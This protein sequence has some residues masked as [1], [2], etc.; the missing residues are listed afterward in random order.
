MQRILSLPH[1]NHLKWKSPKLH[2]KGGSTSRSQQ[3]RDAAQT[4][5][6]KQ[7]KLVLPGGHLCWRAQVAGTARCHLQAVT[8]ADVVS[9]S[10][11]EDPKEL[12]VQPAQHQPVPLGAGFPSQPRV[13]QGDVRS[14][15]FCCLPLKQRSPLILN[16]LKF[17]IRL[18]QLPRN[19]FYKQH[20]AINTLTKTIK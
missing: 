2:Q 9:L 11:E 16:Y 12:P 5:A 10:S 7:N 1:P 19:R 3:V 4:S 14:A 17:S 8:G 20:H 6:L 18:K 13:W 15:S